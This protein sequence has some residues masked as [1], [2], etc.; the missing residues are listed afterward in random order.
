MAHPG[1]TAGF[2]PSKRR[3]NMI[4]GRNLLVISWCV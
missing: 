1:S 4:D 3:P 2:R